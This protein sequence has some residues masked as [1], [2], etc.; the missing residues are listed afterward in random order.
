MHGNGFQNIAIFG[1]HGAIGGALLEEIC[2][3]Y[4][5]A[6]ITALSREAGTLP[7]H[8]TFIP[9]D[10]SVEETVAAAAKS[11]GR[12]HS[13]DL[14]LIA[15]GL[16]HE[17]DLQPEKALRSLSPAHFHKVMEV[18]CL[19]P[20]LVMKHFLPLLPRKSKS[21]LAAISARVGSISDNYLGG[22]YSY[23][24]SKAALNMIIKSAAI[25]TARRAP[26]ATLIGLHPGT[27]ASDL[28]DPF[29]GN[30]T[31]DKLFT[32]AYS[33]ERLIDVIE[34]ITPDQSGRCFAYDG[35]EV[36]A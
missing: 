19:G 21:V 31:E 16:L 17:G 11:I 26:E 20:A 35:T 6:N 34:G 13:L 2:R 36:P 8:V 18:N 14:V 7:D 3:R 25:E 4:P 12:D 1:S 22:W 33:A 27:V 24:A 10:F 32:P 5:K 9:I 15:T 23:R 28:S 30:V 29:S